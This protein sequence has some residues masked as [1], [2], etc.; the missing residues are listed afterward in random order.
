MAKKKILIHPNGKEFTFPKEQADAIMA[1][2][3]N[4]GWEWKTKPTDVSPEKESSTNQNVGNGPG[5]RRHKKDS[6][7]AEE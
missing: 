7:R 4:G 6:K 2:E 5:N 3:N 1:R